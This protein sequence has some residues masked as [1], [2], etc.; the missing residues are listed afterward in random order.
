MTLESRRN[1]YSVNEKRSDSPRNLRLRMKDKSIKT[2]QQ[3]RVLNQNNL[4]DMLSI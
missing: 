4:S 1:N 3:R 2:S